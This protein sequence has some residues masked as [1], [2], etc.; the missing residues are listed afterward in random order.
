MIVLFAI[1]DFIAFY[2]FF[3]LINCSVGAYFQY[4]K[5]EHDMYFF[6][7]YF[8]WFFL[9]WIMLPKLLIDFFKKK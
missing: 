6:S 4:K 2:L 8:G 1:E 3:A 5:I 7:N 9:W